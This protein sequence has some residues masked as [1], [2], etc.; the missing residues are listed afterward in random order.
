MQTGRVSGGIHFHGPGNAR[1]RPPASPPPR[2]LPADVAGFVNRVHELDQLNAVVAG[3][4]GDP[5][6]ISVCVIAGT[7]GAGKTSLALRWAHH[8]RDRF[9]TA[10]ST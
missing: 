9:P 10:G 7:A 4:N 2:Q 8:A 3:E 6:I 1:D 5:L